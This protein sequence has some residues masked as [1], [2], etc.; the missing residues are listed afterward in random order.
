ELTV[1]RDAHDVDHHRGPEL[2]GARVRVEQT[3]AV[4]GGMAPPARHEGAVDDHRFSAYLPTEEIGTGTD[5]NPDRLR[6]KRSRPGRPRAA[7]GEGGGELDRLPVRGRVAGRPVRGAPVARNDV[8][9]AFDGEPERLELA[10][11]VVHRF[12][13][14]ARSG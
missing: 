13:I 11:H 14:R 6:R 12:A 2:H 7:H 3:R 5:S 10:D 4:T 8:R 9:K 1:A